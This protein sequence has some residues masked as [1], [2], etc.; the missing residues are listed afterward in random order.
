MQHFTKLGYLVSILCIVFGDVRLIYSQDSE[1]AQALIAQLDSEVYSVRSE[2]VKKLW[3]LNERAAP[4]VVRHFVL[5]ETNSEVS[6]NILA[7][8]NDWNRAYWLGQSSDSVRESISQQLVLLKGGRLSERN[9]EKLNK[10]EQIVDSVKL[11]PK[12]AS[13]RLESLGAKVSYSAPTYSEEYNKYHVAL[14]SDWE[15]K[16]EHWLIIAELIESKNDVLQVYCAHGR[17]FDNKCLENLSEVK[18]HIWSMSL[19]G[20]GISGK[21]GMGISGQV[22]TSLAMFEN[23]QSLHLDADSDVSD[24]ELAKLILALE[25]VTELSLPKNSGTSTLK[26]V[27]KLDKLKT[28]M[29]EVDKL[30]ASDLELLGGHRNLE[31]L[32]IGSESKLANK[33]A[34]IPNLPAL[35][36]LVIDSSAALSEHEMKHIEKCEKLEELAIFSKPTNPTLLRN[37]SI[38]PR[39][40]KFE[41]NEKN[42]LEK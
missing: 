1:K 12:E 10:I 21:D 20:L 37:F 42:M 28:L 16:P 4:H 41:F 31:L 25:K 38:P 30:S 32:I 35:K 19:Y 13:K 36:D 8:I 26:A 3:Q 34:F 11:T 6:N 23:L 39:L 14:H 24:G 5:A 22:L 40:R 18:T 27:S 2:A 17:Q 7:L 33:L 9:K 29:F 15:G